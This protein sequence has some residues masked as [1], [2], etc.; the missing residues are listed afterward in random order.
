MSNRILSFDVEYA[1]G[2]VGLVLIVVVAALANHGYAEKRG[3]RNRFTGLLARRAIDGIA[4]IGWLVDHILPTPQR[5]PGSGLRASR[6]AAC[7][8][9]KA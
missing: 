5:P 4:V 1:L 8:S 2:S 9:T 3:M 7:V 6:V